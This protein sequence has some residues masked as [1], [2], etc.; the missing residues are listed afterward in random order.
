MS[1]A[2]FSREHSWHWIVRFQK[3]KKYIYIFFLYRVSEAEDTRGR[4]DRG[5]L[6]EERA[7][8]GQQETVGDIPALA[9]ASQ[10]PLPSPFDRAISR[11]C[12]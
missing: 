6:E 3:K 1:H 8:E 9:E 11:H 5:L 12:S 7:K 4:G 2:D 10:P